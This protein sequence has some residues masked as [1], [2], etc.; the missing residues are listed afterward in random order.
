[1]LLIANLQRESRMTSMHGRKLPWVQ[2]NAIA[3]ARAMINENYRQELSLRV[4]ADGVHLNP[5]YF[6]RLFTAACGI[7]PLQYL[8]EVRISH[9]KYELLNTDRSVTEIAELCG[10]STY[11]YFCAV[12]RKRCGMSPRDFRKKANNYYDTK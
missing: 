8:T 6:H 1:M 5:N 11:N 3:I 9:A 7:T 12:F 4:L 2:R 10:F